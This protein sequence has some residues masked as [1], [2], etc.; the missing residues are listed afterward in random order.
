MTVYTLKVADIYVKEAPHEIVEFFCQH[1][2]PD[3]KDQVINEH[4]YSLNF[5]LPHDDVSAASAFSKLENE[6]MEFRKECGNVSY[7]RFR[8]S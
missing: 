3:Y 7:V 2:E 5:E 4:L 1:I 6:L 8:W